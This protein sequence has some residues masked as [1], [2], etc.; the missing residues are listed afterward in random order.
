MLSMEDERVVGQE[1]ARR[2]AT[3][4][5][6]KQAPTAEILAALRRIR[7][8]LLAKG[9]GDSV[10]PL[11]VGKNGTPRLTK[12]ETGSPVAREEWTAQQV[13]C[14][15]LNIS[16]K[17]VDVHKHQLR[18]KLKLRTDLDLARHAAC[19]CRMRPGRHPLPLE[20]AAPS[21]C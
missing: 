17:T 6:M 2:G 10:E 4:Y 7:A 16:D 14:T 18:R 1:L 3:A 5:V 8:A 13:D 11:P 20:Q 9:S 15:G 12:R 19:S 21:G